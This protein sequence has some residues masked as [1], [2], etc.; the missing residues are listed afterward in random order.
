MSEALQSAFVI[1]AGS[2][3]DRLERAL[4]ALEQRPRDRPELDEAFRA[5][6]TLK[7]S[8]SVIGNVEIEWFAH[9]IESVL[10]RVRCST[11]AVGPH[12]VSTLLACA[13]HLRFLV[14][15]AGMEEATPEFAEYDRARLIGELVPYLGGELTLSD[16][17]GGLPQAGHWRLSLRF[18][19]DVFRQGLDPAY[20]LHHLASIGTLG[21][22]RTLTDCLPVVDR[23][24]PELCYLRFE[25]ELETARDKQAI[26]DVFACVRESCELRIRPPAHQLHSY[27]ELI[28]ALP[29]SELRLGE[30][31]V[32]VGALTADELAGAL[33]A[34]RVGQETGATPIGTI[35]VEHGYVE[36]ELVRVAAA[37]QAEIRA[38]MAQET[39]Y[40]KLPLAQF[41]RLLGQ[42]ETLKDGLATAA[43]PQ[44]QLAAE[45]EEVFRLASAL[46]TVRGAECFER[47][48]RTVR[49]LA[50]ELGKE[51]DFE[52]IGGA[53]EI[54]RTLA[55]TACGAVAHLVRNAIDHG[56]ESPE[57]REAA[58]KP[59]RGTVRL[60]L[61]AA[62]DGLRLE[63]ADDGRGLASA[64]LLA[65]A[66]RRGLLGSDET[67]EREALLALVFTPGFSTRDEAG[68]YSGRGVGLDAVR[69]TALALGG[70]VALESEPGHGTRVLLRLPANAPSV[71]RA[72]T[73][74]D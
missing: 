28:R 50:L 29:D 69:E 17:G 9:V 23:Y 57:A 40:L 71:A 33:R 64:E 32:R 22:V 15:L 10:E 70:E 19:P 25:I 43:R 38:R 5:A 49:D 62:E 24:D 45:A 58:G 2:Q 48:G 11:L 63:V 31:L 68:R 73:Q 21:A 4:L 74:A 61:E 30:M 42:L 41:D 6:H 59:R 47:L 46:R 36:P 44:P 20:F 60:A 8:A 53:L 27:A 66:R 56:I 34:Q 7:G 12:M 67:P 52:L 51:V 37:R 55:E 35:L 1:E 13:D 54:D 16:A 26:E 65:A 72:Q 18:S 39:Q 14:G 3:L